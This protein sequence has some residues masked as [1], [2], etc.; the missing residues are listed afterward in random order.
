MTQILSIHS[1]RGGAGKSNV[2]ANLAAT[3]AQDSRVAVIDTDIQSPGVHVLFDFAQQPNMQMLNH[4]LWGECAI[5]ETVQDV[6]ETVEGANGALYL[7][8]S[9]IDSG[10]IGRFLREGYDVSMLTEAFQTLPEALQ[11]DY[12]LIDTHPGVNE[13]TLLSIAVSDFLILMM[14]PDKQDFQ[15]TAVTV[16]LASRLGVP[17]LIIGLNKVPPSLY[18]PALREHVAK[19]FDADVGCAL[20][21]NFEI[22]E[23]GSGGLFTLKFP[24]HPWS[25]ELKLLAQKVKQ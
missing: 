9:S 7:V 18:A 8:P 2:T 11:L 15:G 16:E 20:P 1:F 17:N 5:E 22:A 19:T 23:L 12:L 14:R 6:T 3:L 21:L 10:D 4:Y 25:R 13:E 24:Q